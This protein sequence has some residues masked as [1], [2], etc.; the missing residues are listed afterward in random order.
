MKFTA[1][2][3]GAGLVLGPIGLLTVAYAAVGAGLVFGVSA[4]SS[5]IASLLGHDAGSLRD[6]D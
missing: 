5:R 3:V 2:T 4:L 6:L 1:M